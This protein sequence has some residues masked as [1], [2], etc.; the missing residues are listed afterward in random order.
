MVKSKPKIRN[1]S[2]NAHLRLKPHHQAY[3]CDAATAP[4]PETRATELGWWISHRRSIRSDQSLRRR[5]LASNP[6]SPPMP[7]RVAVAFG[8]ALQASLKVFYTTSLSFS[9][10]IF[11]FCSF[12]VE[13]GLFCFERERAL[14]L[15]ELILSLS[16]YNYSI[17]L[18]PFF[19]FFFFTLSVGVSLCWSIG[20]GEFVFKCWIYLISSSCV[21]LICWVGL[22]GAMWCGVRGGIFELGK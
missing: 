9:L 2:Y 14:F 11:G 1:F 19:S 10:L 20:V 4:P 13:C 3:R 15:F 7:R 8:A 21:N 18:P 12:A 5:C 16:L 6:S 22:D 17:Y